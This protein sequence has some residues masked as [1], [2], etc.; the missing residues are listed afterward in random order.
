[1]E[2]IPNISCSD[3]KEGVHN[4]REMF[5]TAT[6][7]GCSHHTKFNQEILICGTKGHLVLR[8][9]SLYF[10]KNKNLESSEEVIYLESDPPELSQNNNHLSVFDSNTMPEMFPKGA[11]LMFR[12]L[13]SS[14]KTA[15]ITKPEETLGADDPTQTPQ[16]ISSIA[17]FDDGLYVQAVMEAIRLSSKEKSWSKVNVVDNF[18][19]N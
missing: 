9:Q 15:S 19:D 2:C 16:N 6:L 12:H 10:R 17:S 5:V 11:S 7:N 3:D 1:M 8:D 13:S 18:K 4:K 14:I